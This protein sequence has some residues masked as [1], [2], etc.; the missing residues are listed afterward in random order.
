M[1]K[2]A[3]ATRRV[4]AAIPPGRF[5]S[6]NRSYMTKIFSFWRAVRDLPE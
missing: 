5:C 1:C 3:I 2:A 4:D 6:A